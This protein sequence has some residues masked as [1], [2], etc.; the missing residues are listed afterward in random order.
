MDQSLGHHEEV[1]QAIRLRLAGYLIACDPNVHI[2]HHET[3]TQSPESAKR[4]HAGVVRFMNKWEKYFVGN[5]V[6]H[7]N[8]DPDSGEGYDPR[9]IRYTDWNVNSLYL[10]RWILS[11]FP[12][13]NANP[14]TIQTS[15]G[16]MDVIK[17][18]KPAGCYKGRAI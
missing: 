1:D 6:K 18:L 3:S 15:A 12:D 16:P 13:L 11:Q 2:I 17:I 8:P 9:F 10:E 5:S 7:P 14:E 4:I